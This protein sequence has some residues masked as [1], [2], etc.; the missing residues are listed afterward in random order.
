LPKTSTKRKF[1]WGMASQLGSADEIECV[2]C[3]ARYTREN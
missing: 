3:G 1:M 2:A